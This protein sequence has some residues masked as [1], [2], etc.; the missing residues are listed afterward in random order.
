MRIYNIRKNKT[1][2]VDYAQIKRDASFTRLI[3]QNV[4]KH[5]RAPQGEERLFTPLE[6]AVFSPLKI[7]TRKFN[8]TSAIPVCSTP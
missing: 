3:N 4:Y 6:A 2:P 8:Y 1:E 7:E 5:K